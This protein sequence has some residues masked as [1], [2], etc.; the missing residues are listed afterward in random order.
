MSSINIHIRKAEKGLIEKVANI[1]KAE[2]DPASEPEQLKTQIKTVAQAV[3]EV[4]DYCN[5]LHEALET[6][7]KNAVFTKK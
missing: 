2:A 6:I 3:V 1:V 5:S 7:A 4:A